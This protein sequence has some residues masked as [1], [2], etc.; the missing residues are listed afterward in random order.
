MLNSGSSGNR[1]P[2]T[3]K[4]SKDNWLGKLKEKLPDC[5]FANEIPFRK[6]PRI[7]LEQFSLFRG[8]KCFFRGNPCVSE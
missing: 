2:G 3:S 1:W 5:R 4:Q 8:K 7:G 6:I